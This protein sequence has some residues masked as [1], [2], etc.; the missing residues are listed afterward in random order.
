V[1]SDPPYGIKYSPGSGGRGAFGGTAH[2]KFSGKDIVRGDNRPFDPTPFIGLAP[3]VILWGANHYADKLPPSARWLVWDKHLQETGLTFAEAEMAWSNCKGSVRVFR[4]LWNGV[5]KQS[6]CGESREHP[7]QK[8][9]A[10][11]KWCILQAGKPAVIFDPFM[12]SG[13]TGVAA[14]DMGLEFI[15][16]EIEERHFE[17]ACKRILAAQQQLQLAL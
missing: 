5:A 8:P 6:E 10:L 4:H 9:I 17:T 15:G 2:K 14:V 7:T 16:C 3:V 1:I 13:T 12:G 11:M